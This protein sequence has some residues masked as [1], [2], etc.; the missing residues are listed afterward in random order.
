MKS[1][2][3]ILLGLVTTL[4][5]PLVTASGSAQSYPAMVNE[6]RISTNH[7]G[8]LV[9]ERVRNADLIR[10]CA[11]ERGITNLMG[12][13]L[14]YNRTA[15]A[16]EVIRGTNLT[17][18]C[19]PLTFS[20]GTWLINSN[21]TRAERLAFVSVET[22][23]VVNGTL[24]ATERFVYGPTNNLIRFSL[25]GD[26]Q[27]AVPAKG[28]NPPAIYRGTVSARNRPPGD[29]DEGEQGGQGEHHGRGQG[30]GPPPGRGHGHGPLD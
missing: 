22:N 12:L 14:V 1:A 30:N 26:L 2:K 19:T 13:T 9:F 7:N 3:M 18:I 29:E 21:H 10:E 24:A 6:M 16:L 8:D 11:R 4:T 20:G 15:D 17:A 27:Y 5:L 23:N 28:T 25:S